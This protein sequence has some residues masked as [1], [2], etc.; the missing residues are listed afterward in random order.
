[1][2]LALVT[3]TMVNG[4]KNKLEKK[5]NIKLSE[6][7]STYYVQDSDLPYYDELNL[8]YG[9]GEVLLVIRNLQ[10]DCYAID[11]CNTNLN[12]S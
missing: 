9:A 11:S 5:R 10:G 2:I 12:V 1:M 8:S 6:P 4:K 7:R 3:F